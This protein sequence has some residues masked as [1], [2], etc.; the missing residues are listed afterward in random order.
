MIDPRM[1]KLAKTLVNYS[2]KVKP[3]DWVVISSHKVAEPLAAEVYRY[4]L[5]AG[6]YPS[7]LMSS[8][9]IAETLFKEASDEQLKHVS[10]FER[11][12][13]EEADVYINIQA[14]ENTRNLSQIDPARMQLRSAARKGIMDSYLKRSAEGSLRWTLT[15]YPC[16]AYAQEAD[17]T[18]LEYEDFIFRA[19]FCDQDDPV[20]AWNKI[21]AN[22]QRLVNWLKGKKKIH[23]FS[24]N[25]DLQLG[26]DGRT[27]I[28]STGTH[29]MPSGEIFTGPEEQSAN[30]WV[31]FTYPA[32][33]GGREVD[34]VRLEFKDGLVVKST[35]KKNEAYLLKMLEQD[36]GA[37]RLG[38][39]G[40]GTNYGITQFTK[41]ILYD[42]KIGGT[43]H[44]ALGASYPETGGK[45][46]SG[47]HWDMICDMRKD[48]E[49]VVDG[50]L[51]YKDGEFK[52]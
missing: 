8:D 5:R 41:S 40:I 36:A 38:E 3:G 13:F 2:V 30:G 35:A 24:P 18:L 17:M 37:K 34:G 6:G 32:I 22:Q 1:E 14:A 47:L 15:N 49:I 25:I 48:S 26:I 11:L 20:K 29:N 10:P 16:A 12:P 33:T 9:A 50:K 4:V 42:E 19:T 39:L 46:E 23:L 21:E 28:N 7:L 44:L 45:N 52:I 31:E 27:F 51:F 43:I